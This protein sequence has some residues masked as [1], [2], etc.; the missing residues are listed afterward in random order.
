MSKNSGTNRQQKLELEIIDLKARLKEAE[1]T[2]AAIQNET[3]EKNIFENYYR[4]LFEHIADAIM[5]TAPDG[6]IFAANP[7]ACR[8]FG[9]PE[10][11]ICQLGR[12][13]LVDTTDPRLSMAIQKREQTGMF[14]G[15]LTFLRADGQSFPGEI[16]SVV[17]IDENG[18][19]RTSMLIHDLTWLKQVE[20]ALRESENF[21]KGML[22]SIPA[23][24]CSLDETGKILTVNKAWR[25]FADQNPPSPSHYC[26]GMNY[27]EVCDRAGGPNSEKAAEFG[28]GLLAVLLGETEQF[29]LEYS[30]HAPGGEK[31]WFN[32]SVTRFI[33]QGPIRAVVTH[34]N[35]TE[36]KRSEGELEY[37]Y[38]Q[39]R[40]GHEQLQ[41][42]SQRLLQVQEDER[43]SIACELHDEIGQSLTAIKIDLQI[44]QRMAKG[45]FDFTDGIRTVEQTLQQVR[46]LSLNLH[47]SL[48]DDLGLVPALRW[49]LSHQVWSTN[50]TTQFNT[51]LTDQ[52][53]KP[54]LE[55]TCFRVAQEALTNMLRHAQASQVTVELWR[56]ENDLHLCVRD[57]GVG[58]DLAVAKNN[59]AHGQSVGLFS[60]QE[61][62]NLVRGCLEVSSV[63][64]HG[65]TVH[66]CFPLTQTNISAR[67]RKKKE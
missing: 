13:G 56:R 51:N 3:K 63:V 8:M 7:A 20:H 27:L 15:E 2:L 24:I 32:A 48:L 29:M 42:L 4:P 35:I 65:T 31:R 28:A 67:R 44:A 52:R 37:L 66:A 18:Q 50:L 38:E 36:R 40:L 34:T 60:M 22:D 21:S 25:D 55:I 10:S 49:M 64:G 61:R 17:F 57:N 19:S 14:M 12:Y 47:P 39:I 33:D 30:C 59:A 6:R 11:E 16:S 23:H 26:V 62:V 46:D 1:N 54:D 53:F 45:D 43:R 58:F 41:A 9:R 5:L